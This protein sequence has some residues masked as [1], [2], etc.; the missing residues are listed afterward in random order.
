[1]AKSL[2]K[3]S[4]GSAFDLANEILSYASEKN[5]I[6][7]RN[8]LLEN[9]EGQVISNIEWKLAG[10]REDLCHGFPADYLTHIRSF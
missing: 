9:F 2:I 4:S 6:S 5:L 8:F 3:N 1:M 10:L 7:E